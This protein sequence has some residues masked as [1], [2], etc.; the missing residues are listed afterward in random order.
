MTGERLW[1][2]FTNF[3][4][5]CRTLTAKL[6]TNLSRIPSGNQ[7]HDVFKGYIRDCYKSIYVSFALALYI[8]WLFVHIKHKLI[9]LSLHHLLTAWPRGGFQ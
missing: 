9:Y 2:K 4:A 5:E 6:P 7:L 1:D 8:N 3:R